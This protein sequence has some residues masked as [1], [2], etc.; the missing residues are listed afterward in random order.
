MIYIYILCRYTVYI[1]ILIY[2]MY[3]YITLSTSCNGLEEK[4]TAD[5]T[6]DVLFQAVPLTPEYASK[7]ASGS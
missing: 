4:L 1:Y 2:A 3:A 7:S 6:L 5:L